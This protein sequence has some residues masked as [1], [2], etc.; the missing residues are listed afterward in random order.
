MKSSI[1]QNKMEEIRSV[2]NGW[3]DKGTLRAREECGIIKIFGA[4]KFSFS[5]CLIILGYRSSAMK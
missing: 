3:E 4:E 5:L 2:T 1:T